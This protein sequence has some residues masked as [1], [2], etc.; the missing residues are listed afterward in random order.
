MLLSIIVILYTAGVDYAVSTALVFNVT[1]SAGSLTSSF[2]VN[3]INDMIQ[4]DNETFNI[5][6]RLLPSCL[7]LSLGT[8][9]STVMIIDNDGTLVLLHSVII[10]CYCYCTV[11]MIT[12]TSSTF[13]GSELSGVISATVIKSGGIVSSRDINVSITFTEGTA[14]GTYIIH[15][16]YVCTYCNSIYTC[17]ENQISLIRIYEPKLLSNS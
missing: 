13:N 16:N 7:S 12:F 6:I 10:T 14:T 4:E 5:A 8:S 9:S 11:A 15:N 3:I 17:L 2:D 1:I